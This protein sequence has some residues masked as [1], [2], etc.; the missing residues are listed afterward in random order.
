MSQPNYSLK[1]IRHSASHVLAQAI[2]AVFPEAKLGIGPAIDEG[3]YYDFELSRPLSDADLAELEAKMRDIVAQDQTF[4]SSVKSRA[5]AESLL[6]A[7]N[8]TYKLE[9]IQDLNLPDY[10]FYENG[11]F[12]DLCRGPHVASTSQIGVIKLLKVSGAYWRGSEKNPMLQRVYGTAFHTQADLDAYLFRLEEAQK[13]DHRVLGKALDLFSIQEEIGGGLILWHP[14]GAKVRHLIESYWR[15]LHINAGYDLLYSP[16]V[17]LANLWKT[18]GHLD[19]YAEN[20]YAPLQMDDQDYYL[21]PMNCPF[22][23]LAYTN[24]LHSYRQLP[25]RYAELGTVYRFERSGVL[26]GLMRVRG[27]TQDDAHIICTPDQVESEILAVMRL[28]MSILGEF[29]FDK[30]KIYLSTRPKEKY[31]GDLALWE[32]AETALRQAIDILGVPFEV[33]EGGGAFYGPKIDVKIEDAIGR[34]WQCSTVQFDFNLPERFDMT[35]VGADGQK[36]RPIMIHRALLGSIE[37]FFGILVEHYAGRFPLW[38]APVQVKILSV[39]ETVDETCKAIISQLQAAEIRVEWDA[40]SE[41]IGQK[42]RL[43]I[44]EK[45][46]YLVV[47]GKREAESGLVSVRTHQTDLGTM[48]PEDFIQKLLTE[49]NSK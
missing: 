12:L 47:V 26:H 8:Q 21:K 15:N 49:K 42:I 28:C 40:S 24:R 32:D 17:G 2:L 33:D 27:F 34:E 45:V 6:R 37:R 25:V 5:E 19:F 46:P 29:G 9:I 39:S 10:S 20:M 38:L 48:T 35:Y 7:R 3:F 43:G 22:H 31:V 4:I 44:S 13:R 1:T 14:K 36:H 23:I 16:H 18:S 11:P 30:V 41:K